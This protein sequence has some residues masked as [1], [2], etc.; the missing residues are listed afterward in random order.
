M[1]RIAVAALTVGALVGGGLAAPTQAWDG[2]YGRLRATDK[3]LK[4]GCHAYRYYYR[5]K[6]RTPEW[7]LET[8]LR[9]PSRDTIAH[10]AL[11]NFTDPRRGHSRFRICRNVTR[12]G[13]FKIRGKLT[14]YNGSE[15]TV[16]WIRPVVF[17]MR[18]PG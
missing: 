7:A 11:D 14:R 2:D 10:N 15:Q 17:R 5:I 6:P 8:F 1:R 4:D 12:P 18:R 3:V 13:K 16:V 9:D